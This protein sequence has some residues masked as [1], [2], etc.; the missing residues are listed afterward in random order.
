M[1]KEKQGYFYEEEPREFYVSF[2]PHKSGTYKIEIDGAIESVSQFS[3][4]IHALGMAKEDD[5]IEIHLSNCP[6]GGVDATD[7][8]IHAIRKCQSNVHIIAS[9]GCHS[10]ASHILL[11][12]DSFELAN[13]F[14]SLIHCG[15][16]GN[17]GNVNEVRAQN[18]FDEDF[19][20]RRFKE[21]YEGF[22]TPKEIDDMLDGKDIWLDATQWV[23][24]ATNR[25]QY[26]TKKVEDMQK[27]QKK[28]SRK[29][30]KSVDTPQTV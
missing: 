16:T 2:Y 17:W 12:A 26:F 25:L 5:E 18:K 19:R 11:E 4:A 30:K 23:E 28:T 10:M 22:L 1:K 24:R 13:G 20:V 14:S 29:P 9:G 21:A 3:S 15:S 27:A 6:G 7:S 8:L